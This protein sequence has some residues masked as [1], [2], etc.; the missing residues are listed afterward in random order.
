[1]YVFQRPSIAKKNARSLAFPIHIISIHKSRKTFHDLMKS[2]QII[3]SSY[4]GQFRPKRP[5]KNSIQEPKSGN[6]VIKGR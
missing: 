5:L 4:R 1:M 6:L 3:H 2:N